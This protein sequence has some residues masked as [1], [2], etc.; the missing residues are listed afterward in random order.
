MTS[1]FNGNL[2]RQQSSESSGY[3]NKI[4]SAYQ[5]YQ[6]H[7]C[8]YLIRF[9]CE[10][11]GSVQQ[12]FCF[13]PISLLTPCSR[14]LKNFY[15]ATDS[16]ILTYDT[17]RHHDSYLQA[18]AQEMFR[19][20]LPGSTSSTRCLQVHDTFFFF[21]YLCVI[22]YLFQNTIRQPN[23]WKRSLKCVTAFKEG[24]QFHFG[25]Y[26]FQQFCNHSS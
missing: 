19:L 21:F 7:E 20:H 6:P 4:C 26:A 10:R 8:V 5:L 14:L 18:K 15:K 9:H 23:S 2:S 3:T 1:V 13:Q 11:E 24:V 12:L 25:G 22:Q 17:L 16:V